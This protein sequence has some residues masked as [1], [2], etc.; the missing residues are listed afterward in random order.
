VL[1][2]VVAQA[3]VHGWSATR[4]TATVQLADLHTLMGMPSLADARSEE[5]VK[6]ALAQADRPGATDHT[7]ALLGDAW[8]VRGR[9]LCHAGRAEEGERAL[10][11]AVAL[12]SL[13]DR[14][15]ALIEGMMAL[16]YTRMQLNDIDGALPLLEQAAQLSRTGSRLMRAQVHHYQGE[17]DRRRGRLDQAEKSYRAAIT[18]YASLKH[19]D[20]FYSTANL[21]LTLVRNHPSQA[22]EAAAATTALMDTSKVRRGIAALVSW[23]SLVHLQEPEVHQHWE[24][25]TSWLQTGV[26]DAD[27]ADTA[28][29]AGHRARGAG[30]P[31]RARQAWALAASQYT[32][33]GD[34]HNAQAARALQQST[35]G[36]DP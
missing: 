25:I 36:L 12:Y 1:G 30:F 5:V 11:R 3:D 29:A 14:P 33:L 34:T 6:I 28:M 23:A 27:I 31:Q 2:H 4:V 15:T 9:V 8:R 18:L 26:V 7:R 24:Q 21:A 19:P 13:L 16:A 10:T 32:A 35:D 20:V 17:L 22:R